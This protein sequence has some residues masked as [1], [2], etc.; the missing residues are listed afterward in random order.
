M[1][2]GYFASAAIVA[3]YS[4]PKAT[5]LLVAGYDNYWRQREELQRGAP[6]PLATVDKRNREMGV[7]LA[8]LCRARLAGECPPAPQLR[9]MEP[10]LVPSAPGSP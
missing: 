4:R 1:A 7:A 8:E 6:P 9:M 2:R 10:L 3:A 5:V